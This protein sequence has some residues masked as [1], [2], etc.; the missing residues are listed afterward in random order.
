[1]IIKNPYRFTEHIGLDEPIATTKGVVP[2]LDWCKA[3]AQRL[4]DCGIAAQAV[5]REGKEGKYC[6]A[7]RNAAG[8]KIDLADDDLVGA[9]VKTPAKKSASS[10]SD[11]VTAS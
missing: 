6:Y 3:E 1:M 9:T 8:C 2:G 7:V 4:C 11:M 5:V 10:S